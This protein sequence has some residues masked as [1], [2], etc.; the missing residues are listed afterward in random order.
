MNR[1]GAVVVICDFD[2]E[3]CPKR[4]PHPALSQKERGLVKANLDWRV[5]GV[6]AEF[7]VE[8]VGAVDFE[9][10]LL[11]FEVAERPGVFELVAGGDGVVADVEVV[12]LVRA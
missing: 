12:S 8:A 2:G 5:V 9:V 4:H 1:A 3:G 7:A 11:V 6:A 10:V